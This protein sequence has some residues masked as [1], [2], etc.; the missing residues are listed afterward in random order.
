MTE[1]LKIGVPQKVSDLQQI[2]A[3]NFI[4]AYASSAAL[5][6]S[7]YDITILFGQ[8]V[9]SPEN[10]PRLENSAAIT[11]SWEHANALAVALKRAVE[12]YEKEQKSTVRKAPM[13]EL[14]ISD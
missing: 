6:A 8:V 3:D 10:L 9:M 7:F 11:M 2:R 12:G 14:P 13:A 1:P 4:T 5:A